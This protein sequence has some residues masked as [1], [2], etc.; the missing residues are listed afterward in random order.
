[1]DEILKASFEADFVRMERPYTGTLNPLLEENSTCNN[2][3]QVQTE[4]TR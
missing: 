2:Y 3:L 1:M 4:G